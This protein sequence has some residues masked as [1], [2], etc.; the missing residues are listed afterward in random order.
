MR[1][2][3]FP[4][5]YGRSMRARNAAVLCGAG[6]SVPSKLPDWN[7]LLAEARL[8]LKL[9]EDFSDLALLATYYVSTIDGGRARLTK[10][11][12]EQLTS[13]TFLPC[14]NHEALWSLPVTYLWSLNF[15]TLLEAAHRKLF[16][17]DPRVIDSDDGMQG[18]LATGTRALIKI[19]GGVNQI[20][21]EGGKRLVVTRDDFDAYISE[22]PRTWSRL[23]ADFYT[24]SMLFVGIS[25]ADPNMQ[26][27]LRIVRMASRPV[28]QKHYA[29]VK[30]PD[31]SKPESAQALHRLQVADLRRGGVE[32]VEVDDFDE[33]P[34]LLRRAA[35]HA[36]PPNVL[37]IGSL[38]DPNEWTEFLST[39]GVLLAEDEPRINLIHGGSA[40][41]QTCPIAF[42][43]HM[44]RSTSYSGNRLVQVR[45][46]EAV[47]RNDFIKE[48]RLGTIIFPGTDRADVRRAMCE[49]AAVCVVVGGGA[50]TTEEVDECRKQGIRLIPIPVGEGE[51]QMMWDEIAE[52]S[53]DAPTQEDLEVLR[54]QGPQNAMVA[55]TKSV[56]IQHLFG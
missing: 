41:I 42:A 52:R 54:I 50:H 10:M 11:I 37:L 31:E 40:T 20:E 32:P 38:N 28:T 51:S 6:V 35:I 48:R 56:L 16:N 45:R 36:R 19:H 27:L 21:A 23:L 1:A 46:C 30:P 44:E 18:S 29:I 22:F 47:D 43:E 3:D 14:D 39:L 24:K 33:L 13:G 34:Q 25:F 2:A 7:D 4:K 55:S 17:T 15:D 8:E 12:Y 9:D 26:T 53:H 49:L 5:E